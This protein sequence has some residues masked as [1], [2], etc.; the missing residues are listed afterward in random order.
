MLAIVHKGI[1]IPIFWILLNKRGNSDTT[2]RIALIKRFI[3]IFGQDTISNILADREFVGERWFKWL[4]NQGL[5]FCIRIKKNSKVL[6]RHGKSVQ[7]HL[8]FKDLSV[9]QTVKHE[10]KLIVDGVHVYVSA[11]KLEDNELLIV[12][13][14]ANTHNAVEKYAQRWEIETLFGCLKGRGFGLEDTHL[15]SMKKMKKL[16]AVQAIAFCWSHYVGEYVHENVQPI[17]IK[18]HGRRHKSIFRLGF[19]LILEAFKQCFFNNNSEKYNLD[20][21]TKCNFFG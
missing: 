8:L 3:R 7:I 14:N 6:N 18:K 13:T 2:E 1:A 16:I 15:T 10:R 4:N 11:L 21:K 19:D 17:K 20:S 12:A 5:T 9:G